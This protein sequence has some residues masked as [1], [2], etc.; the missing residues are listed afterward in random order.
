[1]LIVDTFTSSYEGDGMSKRNVLRLAE[2]NGLELMIGT[3][4]GFQVL[5]FDRFGPCGTRYNLSDALLVTLV[6]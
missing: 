2:R 3:T 1:M 5:Y 6:P 4:L